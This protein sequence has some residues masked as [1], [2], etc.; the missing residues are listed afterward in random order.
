MTL[1]FSAPIKSVSRGDGNMLTVQSFDLLAHGLKQSPL[2]MFDD[3]TVRGYP[4][5]PHP[6]AGF[7]AVTY[8]FPDSPGRLRSRDSLG[9]D[10]IV[11]PGGIVWTQAA[12]GLMHEELLADPDQ[13]LHGLQFFV[14]L[15]G[16][17]KSAVPEVF[18]FA[19]DRLP[20]WTSADGACVR[21]VVGDYEGLASPLEPLE[22]FRVLDLALKHSLDIDQ[23]EGEFGVVYARLDAV[24]LI[25]E[26]IVRRIEA[27]CAL[28]F[29]GAGRFRLESVGGSRPLYLSG[30]ANTD[31]VVQHGPFIMRDS[32]E[33]NRAI[34]RYQEGAMGHLASFKAL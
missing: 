4:F 12:G 5:G 7:S 6:H 2:V 9:N 21:I 33:I 29:E 26:G 20:V 27:G 15:T 18:A 1:S 22:P 32:A 19:A 30:L 31:N 10:H 8:V 34:S 24:D 11:G 17:N 23:A 25:H 14:N 3:F 13:S 28:A 16:D